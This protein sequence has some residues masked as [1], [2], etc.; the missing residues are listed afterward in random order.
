MTES[1]T[2]IYLAYTWDGYDGRYCIGVFSDRSLAKKA[3]E[4]TDDWKNKDKERIQNN[5][6]WTDHGNPELYRE[7]AHDIEEFQL[8]VFPGAT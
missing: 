8:D 6:F 7:P 4:T 1:F 5:E 3:L 2:T